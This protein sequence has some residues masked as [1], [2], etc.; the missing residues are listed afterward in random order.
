MAKNTTL[1][2]LMVAKVREL[3]DLESE[4]VEALPKMAEAASDSELQE[5]F[6]NHLAETE[7]QVER[8]ESIFDILGEDKEKTKVEA[9][10]GMKKDAERHIKECEEG[11]LLDFALIGAARTVEHHE[12]SEYMVVQEMAEMLGEE[13]VSALLEE[14]MEE[15]EAAEEKLSELGVQIAER[16]SEEAEEE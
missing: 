10:R 14:T 9:V 8:I 1:R 4:L 7:G 11:D 6:Q 16:L 15:E 5:A 12:M 2:E 3:Y 13:R